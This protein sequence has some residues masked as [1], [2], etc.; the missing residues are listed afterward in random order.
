MY[1]Y[2]ILIRL[3]KTIDTSAVL[4]YLFNC[5]NYCS[6]SDKWFCYFNMAMLSSHVQRC[7][8]SLHEIR[9][10][11][12]YNILNIIYTTIHHTHL[13]TQTHTLQALSQTFI[14]VYRW[15]H[16]CK[17]GLFTIKVD[18]RY[19]YISGSS[20]YN[21]RPFLWVFG[22]FLQEALYW[23]KITG[24]TMN[25]PCKKWKSHE[26]TNES[27]VRGFSWM[28]CCHEISMECIHWPWTSEFSWVYFQSSPWIIHEI[29]AVKIVSK[30]MK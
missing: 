11:V 21:S 1:M 18:I 26:W 16:F 4:N 23:R 10:L 14:W 2:A 19:A 7:P 13:N 8:V 9:S 24:I 5:T 27:C 28:A 22:S 17:N 20:C 15:N 12:D 6:R 30:S 29:L 3:H 25:L